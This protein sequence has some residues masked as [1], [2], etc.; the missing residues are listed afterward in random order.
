MAA[1]LSQWFVAINAESPLEVLVSWNLSYLARIVGIEQDAARKAIR[2]K[3]RMRNEFSDL[4]CKT[5]RESWHDHEPAAGFG[6]TVR[7]FS[8]SGR[9]SEE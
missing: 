2:S 9:R 8:Q 3:R 5:S 6:I 1:I 4:E 7:D